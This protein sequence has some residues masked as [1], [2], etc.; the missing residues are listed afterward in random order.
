MAYL[1]ELEGI[2]AYLESLDLDD[3]TFQNTL[4]SIDFQSDLENNIEYFVKMLKNAQADV[5]MYKAEKEAFYKK[6]KQAEAKVEKYKETIR[7]AMELSQKKK[8]DAGMFKVSLRKSKKV[9]ILDETKIPLD[10]MQEKIEYKPM[11][12]E[13]SKALKSGID[14]SGV[15]LIE[16]ESLQVK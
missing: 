11:K 5:E 8:V 6:Q 7:R 16:T 2:A 15:E 13:I 14:I 10:Y 4:D 9:E 3:E 1:Y 12:S